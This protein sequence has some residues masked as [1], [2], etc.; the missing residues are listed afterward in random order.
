M[1]SASPVASGY[2]MAGLLSMLDS[3]ST[4]STVDFYDAP[5]PLS[6][7]APAG[8][9]VASMSL[10]RPSGVVNM[11]TGVL[12]LFTTYDG[13]IMNNQVPVFARFRTGNGVFIMDCDVRHSDD[14]DNG[15]EL[16]IQVPT[17]FAGGLLKIVNGTFSVA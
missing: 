9:L 10:L 13:T 8:V 11:S 14:P 2:M 1:I 12:T 4:P 6:G 3:F 17:V 15:E 5:R 7:E 16:V